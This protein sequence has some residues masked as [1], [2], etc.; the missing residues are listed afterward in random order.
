[1][2]NCL[3]DCLH[4]MNIVYRNKKDLVLQSGLQHV[5]W[6]SQFAQTICTFTG[7]FLILYHA[8]HMKI[9]KYVWKYMYE[10]IITNYFICFPQLHSLYLQYCSMYKWQVPYCISSLWCRHWH[11]AYVLLD[12][13]HILLLQLDCWLHLSW[14]SLFNCDCFQL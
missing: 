14:T 6:G 4:T 12:N 11:S 3:W 13:F 5:F 9:C 1:M 7:L 10:I 2:M 8:P